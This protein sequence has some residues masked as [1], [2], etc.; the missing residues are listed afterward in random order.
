M[1]TFL[2]PP[3]RRLV[4]RRAC[5]ALGMA[6]LRKGHTVLFWVGFILPVLWIVGALMQPTSS[7]SAVEARTHS[8]PERAA[9]T[10]RGPLAE[11]SCAR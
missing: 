2:R 6:T 1:S 7:A 10:S 11:R 8:I 9:A 4:F 5:G 3:A